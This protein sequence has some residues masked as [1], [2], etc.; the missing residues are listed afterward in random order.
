MTEIRQTLRSLWR[1]R[2]F[3]A[4]AVVMLALGVGA[5]TAIFSVVNSILLKP[6]PYPTPDRLYMVNEVV[7]EL[8]DEYPVLPANAR[9]V[10]DW[11]TGCRV[12]ES[13]GLFS[14]GGAALE[15][16][17]PAEFLQVLQ[18]SHD[19]LPALGVAPALG[20]ALLPE[21]DEPGAAPVIVLSDGLWKRRFGGDPAILGATAAIG[22]ESVTVIGVLPP[23]FRFRIGSIAGAIAP[24]PPSFDAL[25]PLRLA[26]SDIR[27]TGNMNWGAIARLA[28]GVSPTLAEQQMDAVLREYG[29]EREMHGRLTP[30]AEHIAADAAPGLWLLLGAAGAVMLIVCVNL[31]SLLLARAQRREREAAVRKALG[32]GSSR[33]LGWALREGVALGLLG[34]ALSALVAQWAL[35]GLLLLAPADT[36]RLD[37]IALDWAAALALAAGLAMAAGIGAALIRLF[38]SR[39]RPCKRPSASPRR[40]ATP[41]ASRTRALCTHWLRP[42]RL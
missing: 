17:G 29:V 42:R 30:L 35:R 7:P 33:L 1:D 23:T 36:P 2:G 19:F 28:P 22:G 31:S 21:D 6:L 13:L 26:Y 15:G 5:T 40:A 3:T 25:V 12:C 32:S 4:V 37:E 18:V 11:R 39:P 14:A 20:R 27:P 24:M 9:H 41:S 8:A 16:E 38:G 10:D 34:G